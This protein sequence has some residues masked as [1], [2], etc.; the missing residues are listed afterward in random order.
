MHN[1]FE[2]VVG[3]GTDEK[4][5]ILIL[6]HRNTIQRKLI[7][8]VYEEMYQE[9]LLKRLKSELSGNFEVIP[10]TIDT[11]CNSLTSINFPYILTKTKNSY[12]GSL[13]FDHHS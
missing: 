9:D 12:N 5:I 4:A 13:G 1:L 6:G 2:I 7:R 11:M 8:Q 10:T 3:W